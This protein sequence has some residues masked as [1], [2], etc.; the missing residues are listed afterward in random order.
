[1]YSVREFPYDDYYFEMY[2]RLSDSHRMPLYPLVPEPEGHWMAFAH[3]QDKDAGCWVKTYI[4]GLNKPKRSCEQ[5]EIL[6][7]H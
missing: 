4:R 3:D 7:H 1:M 5:G 6:S 2:H